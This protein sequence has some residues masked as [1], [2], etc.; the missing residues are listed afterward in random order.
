MQAWV[1]GSGV[2]AISVSGVRGSAAQ[3][4]CML[5]PVRLFQVF[6]GIL[7]CAW[8]C[9]FLIQGLELEGMVTEAGG[10]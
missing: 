8:I 9:A 3:I 2:V 10:E 6:A 1:E 5:R 7:L 4:E